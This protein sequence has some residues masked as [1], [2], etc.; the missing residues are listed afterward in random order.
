MLKSAGRIPGGRH[1]LTSGAFDSSEGPQPLPIDEYSKLLGDAVFALCP[2]GNQSLDCYRLYE[3]LEAGCIPIVEDSGGANEWRDLFSPCSFY[4][5][6]GWRARVLV[7]SLVHLFH[8]GYWRKVYGDFP[9]PA[10]NHWENLE[11]LL[12]RTD[13]ERTSQRARAW[14]EA[15][16][17]QLRESVRK[18]VVSQ[19][20]GQR[21]PQNI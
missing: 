21:G 2:R 11:M 16:K 9:C 18:I 4:R 1:Y 6:R 19:F 10:I 7:K 3:A 14:W 15:Y 5:I 17:K 13:I 20:G 8:C 12:K